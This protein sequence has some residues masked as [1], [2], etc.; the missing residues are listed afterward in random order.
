MPYAPGTFGSA[1]GFLIAILVRPNDI[2]LL[3]IT[4]LLIT[5][6]IFAADSAEKILGKDSS[7]I[8]IDELC[9][10]FVSI[11]FVPKTF[12]YLF[13]AFLLFRFFDIVKP[14]PVRNIEKMVPGGTGIMMDDVMAG[15][16]AN[17]CLQV[18]ICF[19]A[20]L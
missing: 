19:Q 5:A 20:G 12:G 13:A 4:L 11:L 15:I 6:G 9:G 14:P 10:Y 18:W 17:V 8:V 2:I 7:H 16:Y 3:I 1:A